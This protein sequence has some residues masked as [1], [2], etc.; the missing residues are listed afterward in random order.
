MEAKDKLKFLSGFHFNPPRGSSLLRPLTTK[1]IFIGS[2]E[3]GVDSLDG[4]SSAGPLNVRGIIGDGCKK[5]SDLFEYDEFND[6]LKV[7]EHVLKGLEEVLKLNRSGLTV[8]G[9]VEDLDKDEV[10]K[11]KTFVRKGNEY[12]LP[13][14]RKFYNASCSMQL[15]TRKWFSPL[16]AHV[17]KTCSYQGDAVGVNPHSGHIQILY[18]RMKKHPNLA[19]GDVSGNDFSTQE[20]VSD[21]LFEM[22]RRSYK[23]LTEQDLEELR[24]VVDG[25]FHIYHINKN[26]VYLTFG[27]TASGI[28]PTTLINGVS[29]YST[30]VQAYY[31]CLMTHFDDVSA[32]YKYPFEE[33]MVIV[34]SGDDFCYSF[35]DEVYDA[36]NFVK[37]SKAIHD[38]FGIRVTPIHKEEGFR[39]SYPWSEF[40][41]IQRKVVIEKINGVNYYHGVLNQDCILKALYFEKKSKTEAPNNVLKN[42]MEVSALE[43]MHHGREKFQWFV[44]SFKSNFEAV[45][46]TN[47]PCGDYD[48]YHDRWVDAYRVCCTAKYEN[49]FSYLLGN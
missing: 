49:D 43:F 5:K 42:V 10:R 9:L 48:Y 30:L 20:S 45:T 12:S 36:V 41:L 28:T 38:F 26:D 31:I 37:L 8:R 34:N 11:I 21:Y 39:E 15:A 1:E 19:M 18:N 4:S 6:D 25:L 32:I 16:L 22:V 33:H 40:E 47:W 35:S 3:L 29:I 7:K 27:G 23:D 17:K 14:A 44:E 13:I 24:G 2:P 46:N